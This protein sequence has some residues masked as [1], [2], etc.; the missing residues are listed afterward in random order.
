LQVARDNDS[1][2]LSWGARAVFE[3]ESVHFLQDRKQAH[4]LEPDVAALG[5]W[6]DAEAVPALCRWAATAQPG[7]SDLFVFRGSGYV[8]KASPCAS[9][10][11]MY[12]GACREADEDG[13]RYQE[14]SPSL[15]VVVVRPFCPPVQEEI[16]AT[17]AGLNAVLGTRLEFLTLEDG[18]DL[19][20]NEDAAVNGMPPNRLVEGRLQINGPFL[21][22][23]STDDEGP[24]SLTE[25]DVGRWLSRIASWPM[26]TPAPSTAND[27]LGYPQGWPVCPNCGLPALDG[28]ITCGQVGCAEAARR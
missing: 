4:G 14:A 26:I 11:Y 1:R 15:T 24:L 19:W 25:K 22:A 7:G 3:N 21:I 10:G 5:Q 8:L 9:H 13:R 18:L 17:L 20:C 23:R 28:H 2:T 6:L 27:S 16:P 12:V